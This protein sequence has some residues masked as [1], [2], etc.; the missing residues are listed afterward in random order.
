MSATAPLKER[1]EVVPRDQAEDQEEKKW[2]SRWM[3]LIHRT[4][5]VVGGGAEDYRRIPLLLKS[6]S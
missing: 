6:K 1:P 3:D 5:L 2:G 4:K